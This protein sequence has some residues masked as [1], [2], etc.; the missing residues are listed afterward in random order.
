MKGTFL[1]A[2]ALAALLTALLVGS[3]SADGWIVKADLS[4]AD[5][6]GG[7]FC[8]S[9]N[10]ETPGTWGGEDGLGA[11]T[12]FGDGDPAGYC[13]LTWPPGEKARR[14]ELRVLDGIADDSFDVY[15]MNPGG[16]WALVYSYTD[17]APGSESDYELWVTHDIY[18]FPAGKGQGP[19][20]YLMIVPTNLGWWGYGTYGQLAVDYIALYE[21]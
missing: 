17:K 10:A 2:F 19:E 4:N 18:S 20:V 15:V 16:Q 3:A 11:V 5:L 8:E 7:D 21:H 12:A 6:T 9:F 14:I 1:K 13:T